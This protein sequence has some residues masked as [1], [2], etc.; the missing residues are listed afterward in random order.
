[1]P[2]QCI[3]FPA[4][5]PAQSGRND[6][7]A[8]LRGTTRDFLQLDR[9]A[10]SGIV[11]FV[12]KPI[13]MLPLAV[14]ALLAGGCKSPKTPG[15][16]ADGPVTFRQDLEFLEA[17]TGVHVLRDEGGARVAVVPAWQGR[18]MTSSATGDGGAS[19]GW[20]HHENVRTGIRPVGEREGLARHIH[21]FGGEERFWLG[22][23]G[24][25]Y[26]LFF[27]PP[28]APY[29]FENWFT[30]ALIDTEPFEVT[31]ADDTRVEFDKAA[32]LV[33]RAGTT[34]HIGITRGV[35]L[36]DAGGLAA[37]L[38]IAVPDGAEAVG[39][40]TVNTLSNR[41]EDAWT[42]DGG[43]VSIWLLG[44]FPHGPGVT[45]VVPL[46][47]GPGNA[48][49]AD[50][51]GTLDEDRLVTTGN[52]VFFKGDGEFRSKIGVPPGRSTGVAAAYD[53]GRGRLTI[54]RCDVP[55]NAAD[56]PYV[57]SQWE[58]HAEP[59]AGD[60]IN[61]YND[62]PPAPGEAPL[63]PFYELETSSPA[64]PLQAGEAITHVQATIHLLGDAAALDPVAR[65]VLGVSLEEIT[66]A[67]RE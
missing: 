61:A 30:P 10:D 57:R 45:M 29:T 32:V 47:D 58:D 44:M 59:Y 38:G 17:H 52:A 12:K 41:G 62:G 50:Y 51:F 14:A 23:E 55:E 49:N 21:V 9:R 66:A 67:F 19:L 36:L 3:R 27:P 15:E 2:G 8:A 31:S 40:R 33:N 64:L 20:I 11:R 35:E 1:M 39:Y 63:G 5:M 26:A 56:L 4:A 54:V 34:L 65:A 53:A 18:V 37:T 16:A 42:P 43:L 28:P 22:P 60:L 48:V 24:G 13:R 6:F 46:R 7:A 25:Q